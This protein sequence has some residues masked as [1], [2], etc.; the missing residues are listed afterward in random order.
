MLERSPPSPPTLGDFF[1]PLLSGAKFFQQEEEDDEGEEEEQEKEEERKEEKTEETNR[2]EVRKAGQVKQVHVK[3]SQVKNTREQEWRK[4]TFKRETSKKRETSEDLIT[5][6]PPPPAQEE[7]SLSSSRFNKKDTARL[8]RERLLGEEFEKGKG[9]GLLGL[10]TKK[11]GDE[12]C[13]NTNCRGLVG[14]MECYGGECLMTEGGESEFLDFKVTLD[15]GAV[16]HVTPSDTAPGYEVKESAASRAGG[17]FI[18]ANGEHIPNEGQVTLCLETG[19]V[20]VDSTF[21]VADITQ[22]LWS[23]GRMCDAGSGHEVHFKRDQAVVIDALSGKPLFTIG[24]EPG[25]LYKGD[26]KLRNPKFKGKGGAQG[27]Q[28]QGQ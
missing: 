23:V 25:G 19:N 1:P 16:D 14:V 20:E 24:R 6:P 13:G 26:L 8:R 2:T 4:V 9:E 18:A 5:I 21:Q 27:F 3:P 12:D 7:R 11:C 17:G 28:R 15:S 22:S 10:G